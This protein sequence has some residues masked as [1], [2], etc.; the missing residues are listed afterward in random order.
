VKGRPD[1]AEDMIQV[2]V[3]MAQS[4]MDDTFML[5][6]PESGSADAYANPVRSAIGR[7]DREQL[8]SVR[9]LTT[10]EDIARTASGP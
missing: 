1:E 4:V 3:P 2:Y 6:R 10:L 5:V 9:R 8:V 7:I